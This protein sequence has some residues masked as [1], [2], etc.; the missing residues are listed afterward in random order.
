MLLQ[1]K[2]RRLTDYSKKVSTKRSQTTPVHLM[3]SGSVKVL[4]K[5]VNYCCLDWVFCDDAS[6]RLA[7]R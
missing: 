6:V 2:R 7:W 5:C 4:M 3:I 1:G